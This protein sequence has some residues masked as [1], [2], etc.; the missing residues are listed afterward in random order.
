[1]ENK[2]P[3]SMNDSV[4]TKYN[5]HNEHL[6]QT[7]QT[8]MPNERKLIIDSNY[9]LNI[10]SNLNGLTKHKDNDSNKLTNSC[11]NNLKKFAFLSHQTI[12]DYR[13]QQVSFYLNEIAY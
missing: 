5:K 4:N 13:P 7:N 6:I 9:N 1:M 3:K 8:S 2:L 11:D 12:P 10:K